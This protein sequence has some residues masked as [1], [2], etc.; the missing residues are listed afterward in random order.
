MCDILMKLRGHA[1]L[2]TMFLDSKTD[3]SGIDLSQAPI[4]A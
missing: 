3:K 4:T 1:F 2:T